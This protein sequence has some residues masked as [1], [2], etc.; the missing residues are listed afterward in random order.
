MRTQSIDTSPTVEKKQMDFLRTM[1]ASTR[2]QKTLEM[3]SWT[4]WLAKKAI[5]KA[6]PQWDQKQVQLFFV[7]T[8]YGKPLAL[9]LR[10]FLDE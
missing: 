6:H 10:K 5:L 4:L 7:E 8:H 9:K 3:S 1:K 2:L